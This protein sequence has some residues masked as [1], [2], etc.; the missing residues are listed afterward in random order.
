MS[1]SFSKREQDLD[2]LK[3]YTANISKEG[4][5]KVRKVEASLLVARAKHPKTHGKA[6]AR[7]IRGLYLHYLSQFSDPSR[8][9]RVPCAN[10]FFTINK[11]KK[12]AAE[13]SELRYLGLPDRRLYLY[14]NTPFIIAFRLFSRIAPQRYIFIKYIVSK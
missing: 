3:M 11:I 12:A 13:G 8:L 4:E 6:L 7:R 10:F 2:L 14:A 9:P 1:R 5:F